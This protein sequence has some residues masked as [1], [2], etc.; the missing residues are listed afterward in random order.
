MEKRNVE[1]TENGDVFLDLRRLLAFKSPITIENPPH[2]YTM[3]IN[4]HLYSKQRPLCLSE[5][6]DK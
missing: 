1:E 5:K 6:Y 3:N 4:E 2:H